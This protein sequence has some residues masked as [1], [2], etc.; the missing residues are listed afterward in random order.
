[1]KYLAEESGLLI[2]D[3]IRLILNHAVQLEGKQS[4]LARAIGVTEN[5]IS[6]WLGKTLKDTA[7]ITWDQWKKV[8]AYL[9]KVELIDAE[10]PKWM[11]PSQ[12]RE[13]LEA[14]SAGAGSGGD[15]GDGRRLLY[16][17][18][19]LNA[20][21]RA[22]LLKTAESLAATPGLTNSSSQPAENKAE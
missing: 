10:D 13:R 2:D 11:L 4:K 6:N 7:S 14:L 1:M 18:G 16:L 17:F 12:M 21:G 9:I 3:D 20:A 5:C 19:Q 15:G 22:A 8:R